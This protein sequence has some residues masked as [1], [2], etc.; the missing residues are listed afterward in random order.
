MANYPEI[1]MSRIFMVMILI[2]FHC[3]TN[4][5]IEAFHRNET[6]QFTV[7]PVLR[8]HPREGQKVAA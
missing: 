3:K 1:Q 6:S 5:L 4:D 2:Q 8:G 7:M